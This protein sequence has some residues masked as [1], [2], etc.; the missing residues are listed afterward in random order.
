[1]TFLSEIKDAI[2]LLK[3]NKSKISSIAGN[4]SAT[5][6]GVI[7]LVIP[8]VLNII[9]SSLSFSSGFGSIFSRYLL[10][11][12]FIPALSYAGT[13]FLM[14][15]VAEKVFHGGK[16][17][18]GFFRIMAY[19]SVAMGVTVVP[20]L[21]MLLGIMDAYGL[22]RLLYIIAGAWV[23]YVAFHVLMEHSKLTKENAIFTVVAG[24]VIS[25]IIESILASLL[26]G[27]GYRLY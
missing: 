17:H 24:I 20:F 18:V 12:I 8:P 22:F 15:L 21:F 11:P 27:V 14:S 10:W 9:F 1:M 6:F 23:L 5:V 3:L 2:Q 13:S 7:F 16:D 19:A 4:K 25:I 26:V